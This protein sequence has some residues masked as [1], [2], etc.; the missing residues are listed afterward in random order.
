MVVAIFCHGTVTAF[1]P[2]AVHELVH[3]TV[4]KS[5]WL[6]DIFVRFF[7]FFSWGNFAGFWAG[8][9]EHHLFALHDPHDLEETVPK[10]VGWKDVR[11][12]LFQPMAM[13]WTIRDKLTVARGKHVGPWQDYLL[14][15]QERRHAV[16]GWSRFLLIGHGLI[17]IA[18]IV[19]AITVSPLFWLVPRVDQLY[20]YVRQN[21]A[22]DH[23]RDATHWYAG[24]R[25]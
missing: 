25:Q 17:A 18:S 10:T 19:A 2:N 15:G 8:H 7:A 9:A 24:S 3:G 20:A 13:Y 4:F 16:Y 22:D 12:S 6:N 1:F 11:G 23:E 14:A 21:T 5:K